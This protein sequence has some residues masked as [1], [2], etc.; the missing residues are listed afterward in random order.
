MGWKPSALGRAVAEDRREFVPDPVAIQGTALSGS[1]IECQRFGQDARLT[2]TDLRAAVTQA[3]AQRKKRRMSRRRRWSGLHGWICERSGARKGRIITFYSYKGGTGRSMALAN[4]AWLLALNGLR[5]LVI[6]WDLEAPGV[7]RYFH[8]FTDDK[9]L[10]QTEGLLDFVENLAAH[11]AVSKEPL[12]DD[13]V[14]IIEYVQ[15]LEWPSNSASR[16]NWKQFGPRARI[17]LLT[18][19]R[20]GPGLCAQTRNVQLDRFL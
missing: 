9:E 16:I 17:D 8:P 6:D 2:L 12:A 19:G 18:A 3:G 5:V 1:D 14:D 15:L 11:A 13:E 7:H 10:L 20:Q 4:V